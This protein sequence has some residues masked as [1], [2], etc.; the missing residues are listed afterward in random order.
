MLQQGDFTHTRLPVY[1][2][3]PGGK[4]YTEL[5]MTTPGVEPGLSRPRRDV[6]TT[7]RCGR[8]SSRQPLAIQPAASPP[9][10]RQPGANL[11]CIIPFLTDDPRR[12]SGYVDK[13][14]IN[15]VPTLVD[16]RVILVLKTCATG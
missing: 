5:R 3:S 9:A 6:L 15:R 13:Y 2:L 1:E 14:K 12:E 10:S 16:V 11:L 7:R 4:R 8:L